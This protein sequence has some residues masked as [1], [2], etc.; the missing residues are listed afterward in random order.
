GRGLVLQNLLYN[1]V[2]QRRAEIIGKVG[3]GVVVAHTGEAFV[4][5]IGRFLSIRVGQP[6]TPLRFNGLLAHLALKFLLVYL[7]APE[8]F[9]AHSLT[10]RIGQ[11]GIL[12]K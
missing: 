2:E 6:F 7:A 12:S 8:Q 4:P 1:L 11:N 9:L 5:D 3:V 10:Y